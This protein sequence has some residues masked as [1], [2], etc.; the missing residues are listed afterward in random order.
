MFGTVAS[1]KNKVIYG[2]KENVKTFNP[3]KIT[4]IY[5][6]KMIKDFNNSTT[7]REK[8]LSFFGFL[9]W[10]PKNINKSK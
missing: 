4:F 1:E 7:T 3:V 6:I 10:E 9:E 8:F 2:I 5:W